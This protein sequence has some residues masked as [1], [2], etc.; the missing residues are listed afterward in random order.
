MDNPRLFIGA[1]IYYCNHFITLDDDIRKVESK[2]PE[3]I[4]YE[5]GM[6]GF[7]FVDVVE[8]EEQGI[9]MQKVINE[10]SER[11]FFGEFISI[12]DLKASNINGKWD[13]AIYN[14]ENNNCIGMVTSPDGFH[15]MMPQTGIIVNHLSSQKK[16]QKSML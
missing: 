15:S 9:T 1:Q 12:D 6:V 5:A 2:D 4:N 11:Y 16:K 3:K 8:Y 13:N 7:R 10:D 14:I